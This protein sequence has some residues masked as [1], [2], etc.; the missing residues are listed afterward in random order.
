MTGRFSPEHDALA[1]IAGPSHDTAPER[2]CHGRIGPNAIVRVAEA[3]EARL[4][5]QVARSLFESAGLLRHWTH[6]PVDMVNEADVACLQAA[7]R[8][9]LGAD[10]ARVIARDAGRRTGDYLLAH[11]IPRPAQLLL[12]LLPPPLAARALARAIARHAWTF[13]GSGT[14]A[15]APGRPFR[16]SITGCPLC[17]DIRAEGPACDYYAATFERIFRALA[18]PRARVTETACQAAGAAACEFAVAW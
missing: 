3:L 16:L 2:G 6:P 5:A 14:F 8:A 17:R 9:A 4:G 7:L 1:G 12:E 11:R 13:A 10:L 15:F 18:S